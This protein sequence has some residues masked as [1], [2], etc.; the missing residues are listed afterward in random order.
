M[1]SSSAT[2]LQEWLVIIP[3]HEGAL[4][5]RISVREQHLSGLKKDE[6]GFW[7]WGGMF[8]TV[9]CHRFFQ[10]ALR[11]VLRCVLR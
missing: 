4:Q 6:E 11:C 5:K 8:F 2:P 10:A 7:L 1:A 3:D 9:S